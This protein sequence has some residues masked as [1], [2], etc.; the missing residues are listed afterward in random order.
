MKRRTTVNGASLL[1]VLMMLLMPGVASATEITQTCTV[2][3]LAVPAGS[4]LPDDPEIVVS[5]FDSPVE[6]EAFIAEGA[7]GDLEQLSSSAPLGR[8]VTALSTVALGSVYTGTS[9]SGSSLLLWGAS[10]TGCYGVTYGF[11]NMADYGTA[12]NNSINSSRAQ[13]GCW[14]THY[15]GATYSGSKI[16]CVPDCA[17]MS[18][19][20][21]K[22]TSVVY[23]PVGQYG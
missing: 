8:G 6:A 9:Y 4:E 21:S 1:T 13:S 16:N 20:G 23:R 2:G 19:M 10:G 3:T 12:W 22:S 18:T 15:D 17:S 5:C 7:P 11:P 14:V